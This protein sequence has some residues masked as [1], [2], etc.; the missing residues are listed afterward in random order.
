MKVRITGKRAMFCNPIFKTERVTYPVPTPGAI[1]GCLRSIYA[2]PQMQ[3]VIKKMIVLNEPVFEQ[4]MSRFVTSK[5][6][7]AAVTAF[8]PSVPRS[9]MMLKDVDYIVDFDIELT[10]IGD[11]SKGDLDNLTKHIEMFKRR[12]R[13]GQYF[14]PPYLGIRECSCDVTLL[15]GEEELKS[16]LTGEYPLGIMVHHVPLDLPT[17]RPGKNTVFYHP[18]MIDGVIDCTKDYP[19]Q[20]NE[21]GDFLKNLINFYDMHA[22]ALGMPKEGYQTAKITYKLSIS[23]SGEP[24]AFTPLNVNSNGKPM[25]S[26]LLV[27]FGAAKSSNIS[28]NFLWGEAD[29][30]LGMDQKRGTDKLEATIR[31]TVAVAGDDP[32]EKLLSVLDFYSNI[33]QWEN[34]LQELT[35]P[36]FNLSTVKGSG[37]IVFEV[38]GQFVFDDPE[39]QNAWEKRISANKKG[40]YGNCI[41]TGEKNVL[42]CENHAL[43]KNV[44]GGSNM[45]R[46]IS[47][48]KATSSLQS[49]GHIGLDTAP[50]S[51]SASFRL[52]AALNWLL[53][54]DLCKQNTKRGSV[55]FWTRSQNEQLQQALKALFSEETPRI[56]IRIEG[57][58]VFYFAELRANGAGRV[59][60]Q[61][62]RR[63][64]T[65]PTLYQELLRYLNTLELTVFSNRFWEVEEVKET[66]GYLLGK[67]FAQIKIAQMDAIP[68]TAFN[69]GIETTYFN[70]ASTRPDVAFTRLMALLKMYLGKADYGISKDIAATLEE[71]EAFDPIYPPALSVQEK[72][73]FSHGYTKNIAI[74]KEQRK[75]QI[76]LAVEKKK[77]KESTEEE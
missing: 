68:S 62:Y 66:N 53:A 73:M 65:G 76:K 4:Q 51:D 46:L 45:A 39:V 8:N 47:I 7:G 26:Q 23:D 28:A 18:R 35:S 14:M 50:I 38:D 21:E 74:L 1:A 36:Y 70:L 13:K 75:K 9:E 58:E 15:S 48:D 64:V 71:L 60:I 16:S 41:V 6:T 12:V 54:N 42:L 55:I 40:V 32:P 20:E 72:S 33:D 24:L 19:M 63:F 34:R 44:F 10:G 43:I 59:F 61:S 11:E 2:K 67:L 69:G 49:Y 37:N 57:G 52:H 25:Y 77:N 27:P 31:L 29:Y 22:S 30:I 17:G 5:S 56:D 3:Y